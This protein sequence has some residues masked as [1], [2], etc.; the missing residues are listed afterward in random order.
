MRC[1]ESAPWHLGIAICVVGLTG[2]QARAVSLL[3][4]TQDRYVT[5]TTSGHNT[6]YDCGGPSLPPCSDSASAQLSAPDFGPFDATV[7]PSCSFLGGFCPSTSANQT[8][9]ITMTS[10][11]ASGGTSSES[12]SGHSG[13]QGGSSSAKSF[14]SVSFTIDEPVQYNVSGILKAE[15]HGTGSGGN[16]AVLGAGWDLYDLSSGTPI[17]GCDFGYANNWCDPNN[18]Q[19]PF[20]R[21][22]MLQAGDYVFTASSAGDASDSSCCGGTYGNSTSYNLSFRLVPEPTTA[23]LLASGIAGLVMFGARHG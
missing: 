6:L 3:P 19:G 9:T 12:W 18:P 14:L 1:F 11:S 10:I 5:A 7:S 13:T 4:L 17:D 23:L 20:S 15:E 16:Y 22:G 21:S 8:S 2:I